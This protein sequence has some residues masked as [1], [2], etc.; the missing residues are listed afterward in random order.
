MGVDFLPSWLSHQPLVETVHLRLTAPH[1]GDNTADLD[2][3]LRALRHRG[4]HPLQVHPPAVGS[5]VQR[6]RQFDYD[7]TAVLGYT[8]CHWELLDI[9]T[10]AEPVV[11]LAF[12]IDLGSSRLAFYLLDLDDGR[13]IA[14]DSVANPQIP[15]G[16]DI[17]TRI[18]FARNDSG[19][20]LL[21]KL[22]VDVFNGTMVRMLGDHGF[23]ASRVYAVATAGNTTMSHFLLGLDAASICRE[24][25]IPVAN[26]FP[27]HHAEGLELAVHP[28]ALVYIFPNV[29][30][31]FGGDLIA[32]ILAS[33]MHR[34]S[35]INI[36]VDV[37]TNAEV[38]VGNRDWLIAC[39]G[40]AGPALEG[41]VV[42][43]GMMAN[44]GA[45]DRVRID[46][47]SQ[48]PSFTVL[49]DEKP[50]GICGSGLIDLIAEMFMAGI[51]T[52]QGKINTKLSSPRIVTTP[53]GPAYVIAF[54]DETADARDLMVSEIDIGI[55]LKS[56][57]AMYTIL[58]VITRKVGVDFGDL[59]HFFVAGSFGNH[60]DPAMAIRIG[61]IPDLPLETY[62]GLG[63][64]A[65]RG[66]AMVVLDRSLLGEIE[67]VCRQI[68]Y[69]ELNVNMELM[70]EFRG[71]LFLPHTD[72]TLFPS[73]RIP[74]RAYGR[75]D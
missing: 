69:V 32:G 63:N 3:L 58:N 43:R 75:D 53:D 35:D 70:L 42:E 41:G 48:Q 51:L 24:P 57:A 23:A 71:A 12:A 21:Q 39:A 33:G 18:N 27:L 66:A 16:E 31:Y 5:L 7:V 67:R 65:G 68:T 50:L 61:M 55:L 13:I 25:Y 36:L 14:Q 46:P 45:I 59:K 8:H 56:K 22:L 1:L 15:H 11:P 19:R 20:R 4:Y 34:S 2:R 49:G 64:T 17:L 29:G 28:R 47:K 62:Q 30:S 9:E 44:P 60:I 6:I 74:E 38:V 52:I 73:V 10:G 72:P 26:H 54:A 40:A 37:G